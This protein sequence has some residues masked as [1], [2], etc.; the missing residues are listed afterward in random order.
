MSI[1]VCQYCEIL[2]DQDF[3][4]EHEDECEYNPDNK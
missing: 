4:C 2:Y 3:N 1:S